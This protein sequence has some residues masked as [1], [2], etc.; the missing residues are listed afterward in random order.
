M[1]KLDFHKFHKLHIFKKRSGP[2][3]VVY[4]V[5]VYFCGAD[6]RRGRARPK[7]ARGRGG[8]REA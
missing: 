7:G 8:G 5:Y 1:K 6:G 2:L 4:C 3:R